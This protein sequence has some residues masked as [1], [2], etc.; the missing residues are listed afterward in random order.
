MIF[1]GVDTSLFT[2]ALTT[3]AFDPL[4]PLLGYWCVT[5]QEMTINGVVVKGTTNAIGVLDTGTSIITGPPKWF[6]PVIA[7]VG[8]LVC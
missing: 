1:G 7:Q 8:G 6:G 3:I 5:L 4:Q 2:G